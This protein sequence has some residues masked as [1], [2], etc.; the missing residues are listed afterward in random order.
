MG[1]QYREVNLQDYVQICMSLKSAAS[2]DY[3][4]SLPTLNPLYS[5]SECLFAPANSE[6][7]AWHMH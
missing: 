3:N 1:L 6:T 5:V 7:K 4:T 2:P